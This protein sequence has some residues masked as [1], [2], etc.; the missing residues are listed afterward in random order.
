[1]QLCFKPMRKYG[2]VLMGGGGGGEG[3]HDG[4]P[5]FIVCQNIVINSLIFYVLWYDGS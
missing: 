3:L 1:M 2:P 5:M 4:D